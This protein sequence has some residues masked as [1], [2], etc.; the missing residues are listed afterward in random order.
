MNQ[1]I[2]KR[3]SRGGMLTTAAA[4]LAAPAAAAPRG[5]VQFVNPSG[6]KPAGYTDAV[7]TSNGR[8]IYLS[9]QVGLD[10]AGNLVGDDALTQCEQIFANIGIALAACNA[11]YAH[12]VKLSFYLL[13][14]EDLPAIRT[15]RDRHVNLSS[16]PTSTA[17]AVV[18]LFKPGV[19]M[20]IDAVAFVPE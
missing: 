4:A 18:A 9:G 16:P 19:L 20:E 2:L 10:R 6:Q 7:V 13:R 8:T 11:T 12:L 5:L 17:V 3:V 15:V 1:A 14:I